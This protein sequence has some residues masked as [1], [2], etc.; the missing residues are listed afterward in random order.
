MI[1]ALHGGEESLGIPKS[2]NIISALPLIWVV[3]IDLGKF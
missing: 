1:T 3:M 2:D